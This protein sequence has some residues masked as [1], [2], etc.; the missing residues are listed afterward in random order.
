[1]YDTAFYAY[2]EELPDTT[3][4]TDTTGIAPIADA[5]S[6]FT[7]TPNPTTGEVTVTLGQPPL[8]P[9]EGGERLTLTIHDAAG[10]EVMRKELARPGIS[11]PL[12]LS[13]F[14]SGTY[15][16]TLTTPTASGTQKLVV[17]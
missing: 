10:N 11:I 12:D 7:L 1:L 6:L 8:T 3:S 15:F 17:K 9:P 5:S 4:T 16:V 14:P 13:A 2:F